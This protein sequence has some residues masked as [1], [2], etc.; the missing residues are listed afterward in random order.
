MLNEKN[1]DT[2]EDASMEVIEENEENEGGAV[3]GVDAVDEDNGENGATNHLNIPS[4]F[5]LANVLVVQPSTLQTKNEKEKS[6]TGA[7]A[8]D[9]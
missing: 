6:A 8:V 3:D 5:E 7:A 9:V 2:E 4:T 1:I